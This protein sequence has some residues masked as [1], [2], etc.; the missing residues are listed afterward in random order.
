MNHS[1]GFLFLPKNTMSVKETT[2]NLLHKILENQD[3][4]TGKQLGKEL[5]KVWSDTFGLDIDQRE[6]IPTQYST[7][8]NAYDSGYCIVYPTRT[9]LNL[10]ATIKRL[11]QN[12]NHV[13][14]IGT[15]PFAPYAIFPLLLGIEAKFTLLEINTYSLDILKKVVSYFD[16]DKYVLDIIEADATIW[17][18]DR[19]YETVLCETPDAGLR[20][21]D[22]FPI[23]QNLYKQLPK[24]TFIPKEIEI[25][26]GTGLTNQVQAFDTLTAAL[27]RGYLKEDHPIPKEENPFIQN[28]ILLDDQYILEPNASKVTMPLFL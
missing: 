13:L 18:A 12:P 16:L 1:K 15:G 28:R 27:K 11:K 6:N 2:I 19:P 7:A 26:A 5:F 8:L 14:Y 20:R 3:R 10:L 24:A 21:E 4:K 22:T 9:R 23:Y 25:L 17:E